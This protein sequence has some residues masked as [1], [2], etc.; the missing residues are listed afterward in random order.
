MTSRRFTRLLTHA[1]FALALAI[2][3]F[4]L[5]PVGLTSLIKDQLNSSVLFWLIEGVLRTAIFL[6]YLTLLTRMRDLRRV[7]SVGNQPGQRVDQAETLV[8]GRQQENAAI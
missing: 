6:G 2:V 5:I 3:L 1:A 8:G 7:A 4:F